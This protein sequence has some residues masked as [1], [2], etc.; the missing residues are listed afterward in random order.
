MAPLYVVCVRGPRLFSPIGFAHRKLLLPPQVMVMTEF[1]VLATWL[2]CQLGIMS[3]KHAHVIMQVGA[4]NS[5]GGCVT[6]DTVVAGGVGY[7]FVVKGGTRCLWRRREKSCRSV[8]A[9]AVPCRGVG[10]LAWPSSSPP[11]SA[12]ASHFLPALPLGPPPPPPPPS[13]PFPGLPVRRHHQ[14]EAHRAA[15]EGLRERHRASQPHRA[16]GAHAGGALRDRGEYQ[17]VGWGWRSVSGSVGFALNGMRR[18]G[19]RLYANRPRPFL[20]SHLLF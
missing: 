5:G 13:S 11:P 4:G 2:A 10:P 15:Q 18:V 6:R 17:A 19:L 1:R 12:P 8:G 20:L 3:G 16:G 14:R 7:R 9:R